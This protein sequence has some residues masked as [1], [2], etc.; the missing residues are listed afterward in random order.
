MAFDRLGDF[1]RSVGLAVYHLLYDSTLSDFMEKSI[2]NSFWYNDFFSCGSDAFENGLDIVCLYLY[3]AG[4]NGVFIMKINGKYIISVP[5]DQISS[6]KQIINLG[7]D[8]FDE[9]LLCEYLNGKF[10]R[11]IGPSWIGYFDG[12]NKHKYAGMAVILKKT[13]KRRA[14]VL[15]DLRKRCTDTEWAHSGICEESE[16]IAALFAHDE[17]VSAASYELWGD[18]I[19]HIGIITHPS[20][21]NKGYAKDVLWLLTKFIEQR[22]LIPQYRTLCVNTSAIGVARHCGYAEYA[23]HIA[24]RLK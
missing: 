17:A 7:Y 16:Y 23:T 4:Y 11:Y 14:L 9:R 6:F 12:K 13:D 21:R 2:I 8:L 15:D 10:E 24:L 3:L 18:K 1:S 20:F 22:S 19:A 5:E